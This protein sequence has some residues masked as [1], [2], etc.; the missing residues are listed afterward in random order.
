MKKRNTTLTWLE[1]CRFGCEMLTIFTQLREAIRMTIIERRVRRL[2]TAA[3]HD[4]FAY[5]VYF[6]DE[7]GVYRDVRI[8]AVHALLRCGMLIC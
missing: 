2:E 4:N 8:T 5:V 7:Y 6:K 3:N 1:C